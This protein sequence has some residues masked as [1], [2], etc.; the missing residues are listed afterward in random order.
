MTFWTKDGLGRGRLIVRSN[1]N[2]QEYN[3]AQENQNAR[4]QIHGL[5][6]RSRRQGK[7]QRCLEM[8]RKLSRNYILKASAEWGSWRRGR[9]QHRFSVPRWGAPDLRLGY[10]SNYLYSDCSSWQVS[11][12][13][14]DFCFPVCNSHLSRLAGTSPLTLGV[15]VAPLVLA[16]FANVSWDASCPLPW[17]FRIVTGLGAVEIA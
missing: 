8:T 2:F 7:D 15:M 11:K 12:W 6:E 9:V 4:Y 1:D 13:Q 14:C 17:G 10:F 5:R 16:V 3:T